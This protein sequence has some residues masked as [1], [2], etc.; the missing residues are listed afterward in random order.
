MCERL[1]PEDRRVDP[2][3]RA[4]LDETERLGNAVADLMRRC[5]AAEC[6]VERLREVL[7]ELKASP[8]FSVP[9]SAGVQALVAALHGH[10]KWVRRR[11]AQALGEDAPPELPSDDPRVQ[12][13]PLEVI[14]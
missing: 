14:R 1:T 5:N 7:R 13:E 2:G 6:E 3:L 8:T 11:A 9:R 10:L 4:W 12:P